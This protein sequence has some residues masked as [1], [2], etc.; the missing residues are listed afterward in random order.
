MNKMTHTFSIL[1]LRAVLAS[2][3]L[4]IFTFFVDPS[5][6]FYTEG[7][8]IIMAVLMF[9]CFRTLYKKAKTPS[10]PTLT[11][12]KKQFY[13]EKGLNN[14]DI[15]F[16]RNQLTK[17]KQ[18]L[19]EIH[20][21]APAHAR[22]ESIFNRYHTI[23]VTKGYFKELAHHPQYLSYA[24]QFLYRDIPTLHELV[25]QYDNMQQQAVKKAKTYQLL[26]EIAVAIEENCHSI[27]LDYIQFRKTDTEHAQTSIQFTKNYAKK[28][29]SHE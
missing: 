2:I 23:E 26:D 7:C 24:D 12:E 27:E 28:E 8:L 22:L 1:V 3:A 6:P 29:N 17:T 14:S 13:M 21:V 9:E 20:Q 16:F 10:S 15:V 4:W 11:K 25:L 19:S 18:Q 5:F